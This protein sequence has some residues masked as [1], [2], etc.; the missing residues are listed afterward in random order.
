M[1]R[2]HVISNYCSHKIHRWNLA[3]SSLYIIV[4]E[5]VL[6][7]KLIKMANFTPPPMKMAIELGSTR[8]QLIQNHL[9]L[10][11]AV[12]MHWTGVVQCY[13][14]QW[15]LDYCIMVL[16]LL[17]IWNISLDFR[18]A[19]QRSY[20]EAHLALCAPSPILTTFKT[21]PLGTLSH[22]ITSIL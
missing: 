18:A 2:L 7:M 14:A 20:H 12:S 3:V 11:S 15:S 5:I 19:K 10:S 22:L 17:A 1:S 9:T 16:L 13:K 4:H 6:H 8:L 21:L